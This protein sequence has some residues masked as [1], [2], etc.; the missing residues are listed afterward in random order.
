VVANAPATKCEADGF[1]GYLEFTAG[2][3][4]YI[5]ASFELPKADWAGTLNLLPTAKSSG[6]S[7][8]TTFAATHFCATQDSATTGGTYAN[9]QNVSISMAG[10]TGVRKAG[11]VLALDTTGCA[12]GDEYRLRLQINANTTNFQLIR[13]S[14]TE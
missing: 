7:D 13:A 11:T 6:T 14:V 10:P 3:D 9:S 2:S 12:K 4:Q 5:Y 1:A 8:P